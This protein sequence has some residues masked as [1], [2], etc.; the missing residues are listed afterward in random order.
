MNFSDAVFWNRMQFAFTVVYHY[1]FPQLTM[2]LAWFLVYFKFRALRYGDE[3]YDR[4]VR[5]WA[6]TFRTQ[7]RRRRRHRYPN[8][9]PVWNQLGWLLPVR[10]RR[11]WTDPGDGGDVRI[12]PGKRVHRCADFWRK[13]AWRL[14]ITS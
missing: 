9:V 14:A 3:Q 1:L 4:A 12:F 7:L 5:F 11:D 6:K 2:G 10:G 8:G 13:T